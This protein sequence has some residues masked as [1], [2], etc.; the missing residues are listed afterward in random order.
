M[1][2]LIDYCITFVLV[3]AFAYFLTRDHWV[4]I[5]ICPKV[6]YAH[7]CSSPQASP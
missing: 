6:E 7:G 3:A 2:P 1:K 4:E 5:S